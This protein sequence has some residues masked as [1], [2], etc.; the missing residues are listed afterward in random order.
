MTIKINERTKFY[1]PFGG[2]NYLYLARY[3][4]VAESGE[5]SFVITAK[6]KAAVTIAVGEKEIRGEVLRGAKPTPTPAQN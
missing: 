3:K 1:E 5:Y 2:V 6:G 4:G